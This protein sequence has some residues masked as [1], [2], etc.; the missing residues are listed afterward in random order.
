MADHNVGDLRIETDS[1]GMVTVICKCGWR[2]A[3]H[4]K[5]EHAVAEWQRHRDR[6]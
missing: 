1:D 2:S 5:A 3:P 6:F 4:K